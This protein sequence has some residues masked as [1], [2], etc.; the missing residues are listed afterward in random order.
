MTDPELI[1][2]ALMELNFPYQLNSHVRGFNGAMA[3]ADIVVILEGNYD[4]GFVAN[5]EGYNTVAD[6]Y[7]VSLRH[8]QTELIRSIYDTYARLHNEKQNVDH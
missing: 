1:V 8:N 3:Q 4:I 7:G 2:A 5:P 6:L